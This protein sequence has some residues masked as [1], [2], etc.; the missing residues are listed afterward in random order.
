LIEQYELDGDSKLQRHMDQEA[1]RDEASRD[2]IL[3][4]VDANYP[5]TCV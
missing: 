3:E 5:R 2:F 1:S 4:W